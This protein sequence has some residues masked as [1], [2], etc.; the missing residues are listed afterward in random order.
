MSEYGVLAEY[1][2]SQFI[3]DLT[4]SMTYRGCRKNGNAPLSGCLL[5]L[6]AECAAVR[7]NLNLNSALS[8]PQ[9]H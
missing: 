3:T 1:L 2:L 8:A 5:Q 9:A 4:K 7:D 6:V